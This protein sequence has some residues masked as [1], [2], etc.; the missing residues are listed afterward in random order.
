M[1][2]NQIENGKQNRILKAIGVF[3]DIFAINFFFLLYSLPIVTIG[4]SLTA[5][6]AVTLKMVRGEE[7]TIFKEF[8][9][10][11]KE[12]FK[13]STIIWLFVLLAF[14]VIAAEVLMIIS[15]E[16]YISTIYSV[17][18]VIEAIIVLMILPF[19]FP[20][21]SRYENTIGNTVKNAFLLSVSNLWSWVK[22]TLLW[23][24]P[25]FLSIYIPILLFYTWY[26]W[27]IIMFG[28]IIYCSSVV[29]RKTFDK[30]SNVQDKEA[31]DKA[32][33]QAEIE[34]SREIRREY[35]RDKFERFKNDADE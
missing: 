11:F 1:A 16:G 8:K 13:K 4:A 7:G 2:E 24:M 21:I 28:L 12:N 19:L 35:M 9:K 17:V 22:I 5:A 14:A 23:F 6:Y 3:G 34:K 18:V 26:L 32:D 33:A 25:I 30:V 20:L 27:L 31:K 15:F 29:I 10:A